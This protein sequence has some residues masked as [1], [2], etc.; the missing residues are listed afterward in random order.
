MEEKN[1]INLFA[2]GTLL[3]D[4]NLRIITSKE[5]SRKEAILLNYRKITPKDSYPFIVPKRGKVTTGA[6]L[7][8]VDPESLK[9]IDK[10][11]NVGT[12]YHRRKVK[13]QSDGELVDAEVYIG[14]VKNIKK[15]MGDGTDITDRIE[16]QLEV[17][18]NNLIKE[19]KA[20]EADNLFEEN[21][22]LRIK[23]E[24]L[25][26]A[27][28]TIIKAHYEWLN[29]PT[30][31]IE[32]ALHADNL[33]KL[34]RIRGNAEVIP[35]SD[36]YI[37]FAVRHIVFNQVEEKIRHDFRGSVKVASEY[38][39]HSISMMLALKFLNGQKSVLKNMMKDMGADH[40]EMS[41]GYIDYARKGIL[42]ADAIYDEHE[43]RELITWV[44]EFRAGGKTP[45][46]AELEFSNI[47]KNAI[48][49][50]PGQDPHY[51]SFYY[52]DDFDLSRRLWKLGGH[53]DSHRYVTSSQD[54]QRGF[55]EYAFGRYMILGD[56]SKPV[57]HDPWILAHL[58]SEGIE[59]ACV[60][61]HSLQISIQINAPSDCLEPSKESHL[62]CLLLLGGD[63]GYDEHGRLR[64]KRIFYNEVVDN[65]GNIN[66]SHEKVHNYSE[67]DGTKNSHTVIEYG[68][69]RLRAD[70][71]Y[72]PLIAALK[73]YQI[74]ANPRPLNP[75]SEERGLLSI[76]MDEKED[77]INWAHSP[78]ALS[79]DDING[80]LS[81][82]EKGLMTEDN[83][84]PAHSK[85][86]I[87]CILQ[88][89]HD[90]MVTKNEF[91][92]SSK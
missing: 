57:T 38:Y 26:S 4:F 59:F 28:E 60:S 25:G 8:D 75:V 32:K 67:D 36:N 72:E 91:I 85:E 1:N 12:Y 11:E 61:P 3:S 20:S 82:V 35:Y 65:F 23:K 31:M 27:V 18:I 79:K 43:L 77:L 47:G 89:I 24:L 29:L 14:I 22:S 41:L 87:A 81:I 37:D 45:L 66:F 54:R 51:D 39:M 21:L 62:I 44:K 84:R 17:K 9:A 74:E 40:Y 19:S 7:F 5:F 63:I 80:F 49:A 58:I 55:L 48:T 53:V 76:S 56:L 2:Y 52:F 50:S 71:D 73:G 78:W 68:F 69:P 90:L 46:G 10:Y 92:K 30:F 88:K 86:Y 64:E 15:V 42:I 70:N 83:G 13:V 34:E 33:P 6:L 16:D